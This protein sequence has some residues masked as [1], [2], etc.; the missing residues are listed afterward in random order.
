MNMNTQTFKNVR[1]LILDM[2]GVL[3]RQ[4]Q[5]IGDLPEI[6]N[7]IKYKKLKVTLATN[8]ASLSIKQYQDKLNK[9]GVTLAPDE[10]INSSQVMTHYLDKRFP[11]GGNLY[12]I[13]EN[14]LRETLTGNKFHLGEE[15]VQAVIVGMDLSL[16]YEKLCRATILIRS[17][18]PFIATNAD[19]TFPTPQGLVPGVG[20]ILACI[21][22]ATSVKPHVVGK[23]APD[24]YEIAM[25][26][27]GVKPKETLVVG[28]RLETDIAGAQTLGCH[29]ALVLSGVTD[30]TAA[31]KWTPAPELIAKDLNSVLDELI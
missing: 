9:F 13:G 11:N 28:D 15:N 2:D 21:E 14:A 20:A 31:Q 24:I 7:R 8:N 26:R 6:F 27:M 3:W 25:T 10:I 12:I 16:N 18:A 5:P 30:I 23:P 4:T 29:T 1:A 19:V 17:G 22:A